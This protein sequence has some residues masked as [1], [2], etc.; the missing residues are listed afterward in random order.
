[1]KKISIS[2]Y[3]GGK[4]YIGMSNGYTFFGIIDGKEKEAV[5]SNFHINWQE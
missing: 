4:E 2:F 1:M 3:K 5:L